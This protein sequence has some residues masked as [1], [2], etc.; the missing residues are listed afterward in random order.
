MPRQGIVVVLFP[1]RNTI[2]LFKYKS[3]KTVL[4][5]CH[6]MILLHLLSNRY[7]FHNSSNRN[8]R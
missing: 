5:I 6:F 3:M 4:Y 8:R 2:K 7:I 1:L